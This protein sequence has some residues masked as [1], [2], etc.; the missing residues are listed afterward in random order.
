MTS[1]GSRIRVGL[2]Q[3]LSAYRP[4]GISRY[5]TELGTALAEL[6]E[7]DL[8]RLLHRSDRSLDEEGIRLRTPPH[9][10]LEPLAIG[11]ELMLK[12]ERL[13]VYHATDFVAPSFVRAPVIATVHD[14]AFIRWPDQLRRDALAYY[15]KI[16]RQSGRT[17]HWITPSAWTR[18][19]LV[20][21][22]GI[23]E[24]S[25]SVIPH[26]VSS[27]VSSGNI[28]D[29][30]ERGPYIVA[31]GT[32]E[33]RKRYSLLL[34]AL[35]R[36]RPRPELVIVGAPGWNTDDLQHRIRRAEPVTWLS[37]ATDADINRLLSNA[38][39]LAIPS[40]AEGFGLGALEAMACGTPVVSSGLGALSEVT[41]DA[42]VVPDLDEPQSW[43]DAIESVI[44]D[45]ERWRKLS[46]DG[47][48]RAREFTWEST[49]RRTACVY[50]EITG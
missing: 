29:R 45:D 35:E 30:D 38:L 12:R 7:I 50:R 1:P 46:A 19:E 3:R 22:V 4:G 5:A 33:P 14:L 25:I 37:N 47:A 9:H 8:V 48:A 49:A 6:P 11:T 39:A 31:V 16:L 42:A 32:V 23:D 21:L 44:H 2:D 24:R 26:G 10:R 34:D 41:G 28:Q 18:S 43:A 20:D 15:R 36:M 17:A 40:L 27:F 13:D